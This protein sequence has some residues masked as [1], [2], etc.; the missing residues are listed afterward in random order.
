[1]IDIPS[2]GPKDRVVQSTNWIAAGTETVN[3]VKP[4]CWFKK[5][6]ALSYPCT[7]HDSSSSSVDDNAIY[8]NAR[9]LD[10]EKSTW[11]TTSLLLTL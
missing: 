11:A 8:L 5:F 1:M 2:S 3:L 9:A 7:N 10:N 4:P 6:D